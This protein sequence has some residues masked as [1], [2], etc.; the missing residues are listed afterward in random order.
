MKILITGASGFIGSFLVEKAL[1]RNMEV[2]AGIR[3]SS[4]REYLQDARISFI[5]LNY[6]DKEKLKQQISEHVSLYGKWDYII[7]NAGITKSL[8]VLD[9]EKVNYLFTRRFIEAL[10]ETN[11]VPGK[12]ILMSSLSAYP[13]PESVYGQSKLKAEHFLESQ[14]NFPYIILRPT[15]VYGPRDKDYLLMLKTVDAGWDITAGF[16]PQKLTFI[17]VKDLVK[18]AFLAL[19]SPIFRKAYCVTDGNVYTDKAYTQIVKTALGKKFTV[20]IRVPLFVLETV[21]VLAEGIARLTKKP[22]TL[23]RDKYK[24]MKQRDWTCDIMPLRQELGFEADYDLERGIAE[25]VT[26]YRNNF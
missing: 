26:W 16:K 2:W 14:T 23:N 11:A 17:Y 6:S 8:D 21:S 3:S 13:N 9:F 19:E 24:I 1:D 20:K 15:G 25:C 12:F 22:S 18:A 10:Q 7:H 4:S 5:D